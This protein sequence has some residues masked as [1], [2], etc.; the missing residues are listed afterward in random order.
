VIVDLGNSLGYAGDELK[1][2][3]NDEIMRIEKE[4]ENENEANRAYEKLK[5]QNCRIS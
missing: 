1:Q 2:L 5:L 3:V 4:K